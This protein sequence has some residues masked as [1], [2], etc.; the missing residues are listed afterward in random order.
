[1][2]IRFEKKAPDASKPDVKPAPKDVSP[3]AP[4]FELESPDTQEPA[5]PPSKR[6]RSKAKAGK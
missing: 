6:G 3:K 4:E 5:E 1:M 2:A